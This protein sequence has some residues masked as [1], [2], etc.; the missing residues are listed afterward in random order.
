MSYKLNFSLEADNDLENILLYIAKDSYESAIIFT[1][2]LLKSIWKRLTWFPYIWKPY[3]LNQRMIVYKWYII[4]YSV[5][6]LKKEV[7]VSKIV[8]PKKYTSYKNII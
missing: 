8:N 7:N 6:D 3:K 4:F 5:N 1:N 2:E